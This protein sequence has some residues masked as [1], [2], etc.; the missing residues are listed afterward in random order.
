[1][2]RRPMW[3]GA[4]IV[5]G[6]GGTLWAERRVRRQVRRATELLS[7]SVAGSEAVQ[8][9]RAM[10]GRLRDAVHVARTERRRREAELWRRIG[11]V[12]PARPHDVT[13]RVVPSGVRP[14]GSHRPH[15]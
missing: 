7:P 14:R 12:P 8:A 9:A 5:L 13:S 15:R 11:D 1:M 4:G 10:G 2:I 3:L 6:V